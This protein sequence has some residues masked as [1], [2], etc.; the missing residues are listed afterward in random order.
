MTLVSEVVS[1]MHAKVFAAL[2]KVYLARPVSAL[3]KV[4]H[5]GWEECA[6][7]FSHSDNVKLC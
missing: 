4:Q 7:A 3:V 5:W 6:E 2:M 1:R